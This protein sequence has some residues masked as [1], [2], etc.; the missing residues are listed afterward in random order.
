MCLVTRLPA[1]SAEVREKDSPSR[2]NW[3]IIRQS[4]SSMNLQGKYCLSCYFFLSCTSRDYIYLLYQWSYLCFNVISSSGLDSATSKQCLALLKQLAQEGRTIICTIHQPSG[5]LFNM[6]DHLYVVADGNC[7]Y[8]GSTHNLV[9]YLTS[10]G[11]HCP[12]HYSPIDF[13]KFN[14]F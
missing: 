4:C 13:C 10:L 7:V 1:S 8:T 6:I 14:I 11:L 2:S 9:P 5:T 3:S 12:T